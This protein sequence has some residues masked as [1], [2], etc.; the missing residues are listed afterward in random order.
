MSTMHSQPDVYDDDPARKPFMILDYDDTKG[1]V[2]AFDECI[3]NYTTARTCRRWPMR[4]F[5]FI[6]DASSLNAFV[7]W[8]LT[9]PNWN[10]H[11]NSTRLDKRRL[12]LLEAAHDLM[13]PMIQ[14]RVD[15]A[16]ICHM[17][18]ITRA[19]NAVGATP[20]MCATTCEDNKQQPKKRGRCASCPRGKDQNVENRCSEFVC[21]KHATKN[22]V[23]NCVQCPYMHH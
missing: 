2:D 23:Y 20:S 10:N 3:S 13:K 19:M 18:S 17:P 22:T 6:V 16:N 15:N 8:S 5:Y 9:K 4:L 11:S 1:A 12:F 7:C 14:S 21:G